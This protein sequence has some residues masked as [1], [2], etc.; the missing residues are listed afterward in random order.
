MY[1]NFINY[2]DS[3]AIT[4]R[5]RCTIVNETLANKPSE[6]VQKAI[7]L[8]NVIP[9]AELQTIGVKDR[10]T[11][12]ILARRIIAKHN[13]LKSVQT[14][15]VQMEQSIQEFKDTFEQLF[16]KVLPPFWD[17]KGKLYDQ[18]EYN[19]LLTQCRMDHSK[20]EGLE[21]NLKGPSLVEY[22]ATDF[23]ILNQFKTV[24]IGLSTMNYSTCIDLEIL[25]K[26][27]MD[28]EIPSDTHWKGIMWLGK[29]KCSFP[30]TNK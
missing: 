30:G 23:D 11:L 4:A 17:G 6:W 12:I 10:T 29:K 8:L 9:T 16:I 13:L 20:F 18:E 19:S 24:N 25:I 3:M 2:K 27:M 26:E 7:N 21:D 28:Y 5:S 1:L 15:V 14:K 22:L